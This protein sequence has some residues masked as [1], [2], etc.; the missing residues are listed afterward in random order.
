MLVVVP[1]EDRGDVILVVV[2]NLVLTS[3][4]ERYRWI[5]FPFYDLEGHHYY[6]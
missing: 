6:L 4:A 5:L 2:P 1:T 3:S